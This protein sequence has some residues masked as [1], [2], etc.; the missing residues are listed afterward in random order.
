MIPLSD[1]DSDQTRTPYVNYIL[2][3]LNIIVFIIYQ[4]M[5]SNLGFTYSY[6]A[7]PA[8]ILTGHDIVTSPTLV[9]DPITGENVEIPGL[10]VTIIPVWLTL[11][12]SMFMQSGP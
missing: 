7:V 12:T 6:A 10:G 8:E 1:D 11:I 9:Q 3:A 2:V 5:G 4:Q